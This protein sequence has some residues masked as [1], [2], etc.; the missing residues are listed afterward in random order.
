MR[1]LDAVMEASFV[2]ITHRNLNLDHIPQLGDDAS[3]RK[4]EVAGVRPRFVSQNVL[5]V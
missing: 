2:L 5:F 4:A 3:G 1:A